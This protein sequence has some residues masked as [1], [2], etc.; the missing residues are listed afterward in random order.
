MK[1][2]ASCSCDAVNL[3]EREDR[4]GRGGG[5]IGVRKGHLPAVI[6]LAEGGTVRAIAN[7]KTI[8]EAKIRGGFA[9]VDAESVTVLTPEANV[10]SE[11]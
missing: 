5:S 1:V 6:A 10:M 4:Q 8:F 9:R 7:G 3:W 2:V 11:H